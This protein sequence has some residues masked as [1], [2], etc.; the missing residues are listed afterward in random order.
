MLLYIILIMIERVRLQRKFAPKNQITIVMRLA[1]IA[2]IVIVFELT[3]IALVCFLNF[4]LHFHLT[5]VPQSTL[6]S[7]QQTFLPLMRL[8]TRTLHLR[9][10]PCFIYL[11]SC[12][13]KTVQQP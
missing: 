13:L 6:R 3:L 8:L 5:Q 12:W 11:T 7:T 9:L 4:S 1:Q 10:A 2:R